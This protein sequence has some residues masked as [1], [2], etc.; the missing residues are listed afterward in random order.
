MPRKKTVRDPD[1]AYHIS[2]RCNNKDWFSVPMPEVWQIFCRYLYF[3]TL[4]YDVEIHAFV[5]M[6]NHYHLILRTP[7]ANIDEAMHYFQRETSR[8]I[9]KA[10]DRINHVY[11]GAYNSCLIRDL[12]HYNNV[13]KYVLRNPVSANITDDVLLYP[14]TT[15]R[16]LLGF[17]LLLIPTY[18]NEDLF[19]NPEGVLRWLNTPHG[20]S[21]Y[22]WIK[23]ALRRSEFE[24]KR[25]RRSGKIPPPDHPTFK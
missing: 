15:L 25:C 16:G 21:D 10:S 17:N 12:N 18:A 1:F 11:G 14:Y 8:C 7:K 2:A 20:Y 22:L 5:L 4:A 13:Y 23:K 24:V 19:A 9:G 3:I 6:N